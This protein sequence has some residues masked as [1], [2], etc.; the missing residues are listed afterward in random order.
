MMNNYT[1]SPN[2]VWL[3]HFH[4]YWNILGVYK[5]LHV[6]VLNKQMKWFMNW[7]RAH[8]NSKNIAS[9]YR[10]VVF[11]YVEHNHPCTKNAAFYSVCDFSNKNIKLLNSSFFFNSCNGFNGFLFLMRNWPIMEILA[12]HLY[13]FITMKISYIVCCTRNY[14]LRM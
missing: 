2:Y 7:T 9:S 11:P 5:S 3:W 14:Y 8:E 13:V 10:N 6:R 4:P 12:F 1:L